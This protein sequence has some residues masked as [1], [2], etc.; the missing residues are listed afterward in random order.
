P[1][2]FRPAESDRI[3][4]RRGQRTAAYQLRPD[5]LHGY[6]GEADSIRVEDFVLI[7]L[8]PTYMNRRTFLSLSGAASLTR[9]FLGAPAPANKRERMLG[10]LAGQGAPNYTPAAFFLHFGNG[11]K[12]GSAAARRHLEFFRHT[13]MDFLKIQFEQAYSRQEFLQKPADWAKLKLARL[14]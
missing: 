8:Y 3:Y 13:D 10:W 11:Y 9:T 14:D 6:R 5:T 7:H 4:G 12:A 1:S 2:E